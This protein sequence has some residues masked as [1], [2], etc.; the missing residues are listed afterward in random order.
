MSDVAMGER[1]AVLESKVAAEERSWAR[2]STMLGSA[3]ALLISILSGGYNIYDNAV[4]RPSQEQEQALGELRQIVARLSEINWKLIDQSDGD[5][6]RVRV[7]QM[8]ASGEKVSLL[9][10]ADQIIAA[11]GGLVGV[12]EYLTLAAEHLNFGNNDKAVRYAEAAI[13]SA[14]GPGMRA[15]AFR[16]KARALFAPGETQDLAKARAAFTDGLRTIGGSGTLSSL[17]LVATLYNDWLVN[18]AYFGDCARLQPLYLEM[19]KALAPLQG[20][21][22]VGAIMSI[23]T[24]ALRNQ[25]RC[26]LR[27]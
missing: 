16:Y 5:P 2:R 26:A 23:G 27:W 25:T 19:Q 3:L 1:I 24:T 10:R 8:T 15:E 14:A 6:Q 9:D 4:L 18:E 21:A 7:V 17:N 12:S 22:D 13:A 11:R 20:S